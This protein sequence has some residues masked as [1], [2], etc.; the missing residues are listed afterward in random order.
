MDLAIVSLGLMDPLYTAFG[1]VMRVLYD[2]IG[3]YG[4]V[5]IVFTII[6]RGLMIPLGINQ[7]KSTLK[8]QALSGEIAEIKRLYPD[9][10]AKQSELQME[11]YKHHG[12]SPMAG[13]LPSILQLIIIWPI[14]RIIQAPLKH[15][16]HVSSENL[17]KIGQIL[18]GMTDAAGQPLISENAA[19]AAAT[20]NIPLLNALEA[21]A[22]ALSR[23]VNEGLINL[24][25]MINVDF[26]GINLGL[27]PTYKPN[28]LFGDSMWTYLPLLLIP[29]FVLATTL[30][31]MKISRIT[32]LNRKQKEIDKERDKKNP[33]RAGQTQQDS[34]E[35][36]M[37]SMN[38]I[39]PIFM[40]WTTFTF[41]AAM[42]LYWII[43]NTM[44]ILQ[45]VII[46]FLFTRKLEQA[47]LNKPEDKSGEVM[48]EVKD[49]EV[50]H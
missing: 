8:Q 13:C 5:I 7:Q 1:W 41:P 22:S 30:V 14:F 11:L 12:A 21:N 4:L 49:A 28:L 23:V 45:S 2:I 3:N 40:L 26:L 47:G 29:L 16:M 6:L 15:I 34:S 36:M 42:G 43:G 46:Y 31:Q 38:I 19:K 24:D 27:T 50:A 20:M 37:K 35:S 39:M 18:Q 33:A 32:M 48:K 44:M 10:K 9:D 17:D 25:Q